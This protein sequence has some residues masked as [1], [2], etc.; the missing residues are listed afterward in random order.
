MPGIFA[1][2]RIAWILAMI[3]GFVLIVVGAVTANWALLIGG[4]VILLFGLVFLIL[5]YVTKGRTD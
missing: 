1:R 5:S 3:L 4:I 2:G